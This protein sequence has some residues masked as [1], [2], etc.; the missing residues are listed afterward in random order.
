MCDF[1]KVKMNG[2][3]YFSNK[4]QKSFQKDQITNLVCKKTEMCSTFWGLMLG[5]IFS[6]LFDSKINSKK[7]SP[8][9]PEKE[10]KNTN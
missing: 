8:G 2:F 5:S 1:S 7:V 9:D 3:L 10:R 4:K 6:C